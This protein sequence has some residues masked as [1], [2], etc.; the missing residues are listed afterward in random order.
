MRGALSTLVI[1]MTAHS[2]AAFAPAPALGLVRLPPSSAL[3]APVT[4]LRVARASLLG[5]VGSR[6]RSSNTVA[7]SKIFPAGA[8]WQA[9]SLFAADNLGLESTSLAFFGAVG[10]GD[11]LGVF[12]GH[13]LFFLLKKLVRHDP[14]IKMGEQL[15]VATLLGGAAFFSGATWQPA[16]NAL[17]F[18]GLDFAGVFLGVGAS[19]TLAFFTGLRVW[20]KLL[21]PSMGAVERNSYQNQKSD[22]Q[23]AV[24]I[25]VKPKPQTEARTGM[26]ITVGILII[27]PFNPPTPNPTT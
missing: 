17:R 12:L 20:R 9:A 1:A 7:I 22:V 6:L 25:G 16:L 21:S 11:F 19:C 26:P 4:G 15:Q 5:R 24:A 10:L 27:H 3:R 23:L 13:T 18:L 14:T 2:C 8:G